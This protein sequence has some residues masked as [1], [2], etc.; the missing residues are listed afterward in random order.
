MV[1]YFWE[2]K[3]SILSNFLIIFKE[4]RMLP[5]AV[6]KTIF[7]F[8]FLIFFKEKLRNCTTSQI[9][10]FRAEVK[11]MVSL[12]PHPNVILSLGACTKSVQQLC[13]VTG[14]YLKFNL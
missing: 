11:V 3:L 7:L 5:V 9:E 1:K 14:K 8:N 2:V 13:L 4:W 12:K 6:S 10:D